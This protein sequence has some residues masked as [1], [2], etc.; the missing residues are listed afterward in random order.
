MDSKNR[1]I[2]VGQKPINSVVDAANYV[3][4][5]LGQPL[6]AFDM[7]KLNPTRIIVRRA[8]EGERIITLDNKEYSLD[9]N[10]LVIADSR[11]PLAIA[12]IKGGKKAEIDRKTKNIII[13]SAN[14]EPTNIRLT[15]QKLGLRTGASVGFEN[16]ISVFLAEQAMERVIELIH[17]IGGGKVVGEKIDFYPVK[18]KPPAISF[19]ISD[20][21]KLLGIAVS[22]KEI[23]SILKRLGIGFKKTRRAG[24]RF[25]RHKPD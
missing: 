9:K 11:E 5:E 15:S 6:H 21:S 4:L 13:E 7:D 14:F 20:I 17:E 12:G 8:K 2:A 25:N 23:I 1:L 10:M 3:M 24:R 22:E 19:R 18:S 16:E